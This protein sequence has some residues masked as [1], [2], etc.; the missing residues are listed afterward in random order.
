[1]FLFDVSNAPGGKSKMG[2]ELDAT[3]KMPAE[4]KQ[5]QTKP[6]KQKFINLNTGKVVES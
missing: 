3:A 1:M 2:V 5:N 4:T 6:K